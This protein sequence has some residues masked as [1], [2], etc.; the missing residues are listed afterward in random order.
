MARWPPDARHPLKAL[1]GS[2]LRQQHRRHRCRMNVVLQRH[3]ELAV[4]AGYIDL[5]VSNASVSRPCFTPPWLKLNLSGLLTSCPKQNVWSN[6]AHRILPFRIRASPNPSRSSGRTLPRLFSARGV[7]PPGYS[8]SAVIRSQLSLVRPW[9][10]QFPIA[11][12]RTPP[13]GSVPSSNRSVVVVPATNPSFE[14][15][16]A[17]AKSTQTLAVLSASFRFAGSTIGPTQSHIAKKHLR[18]VAKI[19]LPTSCAISNV[20]HCQHFRNPAISTAVL[21]PGPLALR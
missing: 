9:F 18:V 12:P 20:S 17:S 19:R 6:P 4:D 15:T 5:A 11:S 8:W 21:Q 14:R 2:V 13:C 1:G 16:F 3:G 10:R 7:H